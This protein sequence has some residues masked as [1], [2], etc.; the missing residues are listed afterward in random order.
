MTSNYESPKMKQ[1]TIVLVAICK[2]TLQE[3]GWT[4]TIPAKGSLLVLHA[5]NDLTRRALRRID[6]EQARDLKDATGLFA[7]NEVTVFA[8]TSSNNVIS[9]LA[10][11]LGNLPEDRFR[12]VDS[13]SLCFA[14]G[15][16]C[17]DT[18]PEAVVV[19]DVTPAS[20]AAGDCYQKTPSLELVDH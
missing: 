9:Q 20:L 11:R 17:K 10:E 6:C 13:L 7:V 16:D 3:L 2:D 4:H 18:S 5:H 14:L 1:P 15:L 8:N 12:Q 19:A